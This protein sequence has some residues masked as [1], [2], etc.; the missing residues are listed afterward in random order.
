[1]PTS[2]KALWKRIMSCWDDGSICCRYHLAK[3]YTAEYSNNQYG[4]IILAD[5]LWSFSRYDEALVALKTAE[6][7]SPPEKVY[8]VYHQRALLYE[9]KGE[10]RRAEH[11]H[12]KA[13][14]QKVS[15]GRLIFLGACLA[16]QGKLTEAKI[17]HQRATRFKKG[18]PEEAHLNL[19]YILRAEERYQDALK[20]FDTALKLCPDYEEAKDAKRDIEKLLEM[21]KRS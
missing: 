10:D 19:G 11:W 3:R 17:H 2:E 21:E 18:D 7:L 1:M 6:R 9:A 20:H 5:A 12:R 15:C 16:R 13:L 8:E 14:D 4:W